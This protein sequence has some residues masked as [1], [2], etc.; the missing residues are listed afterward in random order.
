MPASASC[1]RLSSTLTSRSATPALGPPIRRH[2]NHMYH[3]KKVKSFQ[4]DLPVFYAIYN[5]SAMKM[6]QL[7]EQVSG[8]LIGVFTD[9]LVVE[10]DVNKIECN[11]HIIGG[12]R[13][14][15]IKEFTQLTDTTPRT[16]K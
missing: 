1:H 7:Y 10:G 3:T 13:E 15:D 6:H 14:T 5:I 12:I 2:R 9:T 8:K 4:N 16:T 11:K